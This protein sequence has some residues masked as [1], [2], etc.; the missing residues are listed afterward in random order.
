MSVSRLEISTLQ[1][2]DSQRSVQAALPGLRQAYVHMVYQVGYPPDTRSADHSDI[3]LMTM[4]PVLTA[5]G[6]RR[7]NIAA[8]STIRN[9]KSSV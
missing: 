9:I 2:L 3:Q 7:R 6:A 8:G 5:M 1:R 4:G